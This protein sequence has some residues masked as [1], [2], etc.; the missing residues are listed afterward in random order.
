MY[1]KKLRQI[2]LQ[3]LRQFS[4]ISIRNLCIGFRICVFLKINNLLPRND[5]VRNVENGYHI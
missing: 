5:Y 1:L 2:V 3:K 4:K